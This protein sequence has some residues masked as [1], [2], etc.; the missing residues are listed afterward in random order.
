MILSVLKSR[1]GI[2]IDITMIFGH[3]SVTYA[4]GKIIEKRAPFISFTGLL[5]FGAVLPDLLDKPLSMF[6]PLPGRG[7]AHSAVMQFFFFLIVSALFR[8]RREKLSAVFAGAMLHLIEDFVPLSV[9]LWP[10]LG[11]FPE[12]IHISFTEKI[13][14]Y[15]FHMLAPYSLAVE[16]LS[17][18]VAIYF[19][20]GRMNT[21]IR[22]EPA[23]SETGDI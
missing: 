8:S 23:I 9:L 5:L 3:I 4:A 16:A 14:N 20:S 13:M 2:I 7:L 22:T 6:F 1:I 15:Y 12:V 17:Y 11:P 10:F 21:S 19:L 18:P